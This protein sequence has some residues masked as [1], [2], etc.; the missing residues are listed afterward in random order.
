MTPVPSAADAARLLHQLKQ[1]INAPHQPKPG[2][3]LSPQMALLREW[4]SARL[5]RTHADLLAD[6]EF[7]AASRFFLT[8]IYAPRDFTQRDHDIERM[9]NFM[10][11][12]LPPKILQPLTR[13]IELNT[14]TQTLDARLLDAL[15]ND[16][17]ITDEIT[18]AQYAEA[19][20]I[21]DN[22]DDRVR[23]IEMVSEIGRELSRIAHLPFIAPTVRLMHKPAYRAGWHEL[24]DFLEHGLAAFKRMKHTEQFLDTIAGRE[25]L[26][27]DRIYAR[28]PHPFDI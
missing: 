13:A 7:G 11:K 20:R 25:R 3:G 24:Q 22:Y 2:E 28:H 6:A 15:V 4:Q 10:L 14:L 9:H 17:G 19:Y 12:I 18:E 27:L 5:A 23:Q 16:L 8:D 1:N 21:C 26:I